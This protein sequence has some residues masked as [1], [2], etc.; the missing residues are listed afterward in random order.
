MNNA[1]CRVQPAFEP[2]NIMSKKSSSGL[3][4]QEWDYRQM[5]GQVLSAHSKQKK[6]KK[7]IIDELKITKK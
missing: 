7:H 1:G 3:L 6:N 5:R 2:E 4:K